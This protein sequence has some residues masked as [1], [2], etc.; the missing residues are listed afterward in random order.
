MT[1]YQ[2]DLTDPASRRPLP[3]YV[4]CGPLLI[5]AQEESLR[6]ADV[7]T[8][9]CQVTCV[10]PTSG[11]PTL[12]CPLRVGWKPPSVNFAS[13]FD[14]VPGE[15]E[16]ELLLGEDG[17]PGRTR[18]RAALQPGWRNIE[19]VATFEGARARLFL[20]GTEVATAEPRS[21]AMPG[22]L[23]V[24]IGDRSETATTAQFKGRLERV[25][26]WKGALSPA[27]MAEAPAKYLLFEWRGH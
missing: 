17:E 6:G 22:A 11:P 5:P 8:I 23:P 27:A 26:V 25:Q 9:A 12:S 15:T 21:E 7:L 4:A 13:H 3:P 10:F 14:P 1:S 2:Y 20:D 16:F 19:L 24:V 18:N